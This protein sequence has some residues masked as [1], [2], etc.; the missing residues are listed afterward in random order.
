MKDDTASSTAFTVVQGVLLTARRSSTRALVPSDQVEA[1][2]RMLEASEEG[3]RR[4]RQ[5]ANPVFRTVASAAESLMVPGLPLHYVLRKRVIEDAVTDALKA[6]ATQVVV[7]GAGLDTLGWR[8]HQRYPDVTVIE[9]DHPATSAVK[10]QA[11]EK[12]VTEQASGAMTMLAADLSKVPLRT[13]LEGCDQFSSDQRTIFVCEGVLMYLPTEAVD[14]LFAT[15]RDLTGP[16]TRFA[17][18][19]TAPESSGQTNT[20]LLLRLY[21]KLR[22]EP[23]NWLMEPNRLDA[24][25]ADRGFALVDRTDDR[26]ALARYG[27]ADYTGP[28]HVGEYMTVADVL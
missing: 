13:V 22:S 6:G 17:F 2:T 10:Q 11:V 19:V 25:L 9:V 12:Q 8:L 23:L 3:Q 28:V 7:L 4:L 15:L 26:A 18:T 20:G 27:A 16:S 1:C 5:L 24:F 14:T 21:L